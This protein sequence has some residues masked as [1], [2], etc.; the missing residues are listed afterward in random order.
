MFGYKI[1]IKALFFRRFLK[2]HFS[3]EMKLSLDLQNINNL[4]EYSDQH[5]T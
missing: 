3:K 5:I 4:E 2:F 1:I